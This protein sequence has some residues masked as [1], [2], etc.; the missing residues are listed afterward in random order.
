MTS[1]TK[2]TFTNRANAAGIRQNVFLVPRGEHLK[3]WRS[4]EN[5]RS[6]Y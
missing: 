6:E 1:N 5:T 2:A 3:S 4:T